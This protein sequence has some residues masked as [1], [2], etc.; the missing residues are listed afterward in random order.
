[1]PVDV[2]VH[3]SEVLQDDAKLFEIQFF[4][5]SRLERAEMAEMVL[6]TLWEMDVFC[7]TTGWIWR[8]LNCLTY[9]HHFFKAVRWVGFWWDLILYSTSSSIGFPSAL[10]FA[11]F[12]IETVKDQRDEC[13]YEACMML[14]RCGPR[15]SGQLLLPT[16]PLF[17]PNRPT[18][19]ETGETKL[20]LVERNTKKSAK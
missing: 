10:F 16:K 15:F 4:A 1:M 18:S 3:A 6:Q 13:R 7:K 19:S 12:F 9:L 5:Q 14:S 11:A 8:E 17:P 2:A 20:P